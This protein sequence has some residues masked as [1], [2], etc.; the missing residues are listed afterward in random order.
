MLLV[1]KDNACLHSHGTFVFIFIREFWTF[2]DMFALRVELLVF[3][4]RKDPKSYEEAKRV[5]YW[6]PGQL[7]TAKLASTTKMKIPLL[8]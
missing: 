3:S 6:I 1:K 5:F 4:K 7:T 8:N 2:F